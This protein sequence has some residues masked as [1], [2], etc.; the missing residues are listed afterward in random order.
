MSLLHLNMTQR[1][2]TLSTLTV[3]FK[4]SNEPANGGEFKSFV[5]VCLRGALKQSKAP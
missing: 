5:S 1:L 4:I 3:D 2:D